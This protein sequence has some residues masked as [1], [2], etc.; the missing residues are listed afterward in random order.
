MNSAIHRRRF[1]FLFPPVAPATIETE[2]GSPSCSC[3]LIKTKGDINN[4]IQELVYNFWW[5]FSAWNKNIIKSKQINK[6]QKS[7]L[8]LQRKLDDLFLIISFLIIG[9]EKK[10]LKKRRKWRINENMWFDCRSAANGVA[11]A[12][13]KMSS[14]LSLSLV[15]KKKNALLAFNEKTF[16]SWMKWKGGKLTWHLA[17]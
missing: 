2:N 8:M 10:R 16:D 5:I 1:S 6:E 4:F 7:S 12:P 9:G 3:S 17:G 13:S 11:C 14:S 15:Y